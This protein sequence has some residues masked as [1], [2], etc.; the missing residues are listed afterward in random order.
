LELGAGSS[1]CATS[2][3]IVGTTDCS[4]IPATNPPC[5]VHVRLDYDFRTILSVPPMPASILIARDSRFRISNL[6]PPP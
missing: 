4:L 5:T 6:E 1:D 3:G 2:G